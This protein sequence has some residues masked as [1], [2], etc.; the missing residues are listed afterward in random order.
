MAEASRFFNAVDGDRVYSAADWAEY[1]ASFIGNGV[2]GSPSTN[3]QVSPGDG[4]NVSVAAGLAWINGYFYTND[5]ALTLPL[6]T[7]DGTLPRIDR[8]VI[9]W[10]LA[11]RAI[12]AA[13]KTGTAAS[14]PVAPALQRDTS[15]YELGIADVYVAAG[16]TSVSSANITDR[17]SDSS[18]CGTVSS[19]VSEAHT[20][21]LAGSSLTG[22]L[23]VSKGGTGGADAAAARTNLGITPANIG[24][25]GTDHTHGLAA[26]SLT[27]TLPVVPHRSGQGI[28]G[29]DGNKSR[30]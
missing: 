2:F 28:C 11:N 16:A 26:G 29:G 4:M 6:S 18:L 7:A 12:W 25:S 5:A 19:I 23:P 10:S 30:A 8:V 21:D 13:V 20:H 15:V 14:S 17:R 9:R 3:L 24:A 22:T 27:G 1:F